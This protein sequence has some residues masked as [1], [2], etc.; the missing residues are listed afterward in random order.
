VEDLMTN[1]PPF[2]LGGHRPC[3][4]H[5][6]DDLDKAANRYADVLGCQP[7]YPYPTLGMEQVWCGAALIVLWDITH[8]G[9]AAA[10]PPVMG[11]RKCPPYLHRLEPLC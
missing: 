3:G 9:A 11:G 1:K 2:S 8:P 10:V 6:S 5:R 4:V 7:G